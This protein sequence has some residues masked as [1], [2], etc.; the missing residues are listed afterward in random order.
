MAIDMASHCKD[1]GMDTTPCTGK[2]GCRHKDRWEYYMVRDKL[3]A[4][5][6]M[7]DGFL[8]V[9]CPEQRIGRILRPKDFTRA[10]IN[11][12]DHS[13]DT[14]RRAARKVGRKAAQ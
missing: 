3:W 8:C 10:S 13:W 9:G 14:P 1:C 2:R 6:G 7:Q 4:A 5:A 11:N 12:P